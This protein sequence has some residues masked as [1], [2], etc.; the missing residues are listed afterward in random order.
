MMY[1]AVKSLCTCKDI[2]HCLITFFDVGE[3]GMFGCFNEGIFN[4]ELVRKV[5]GEEVG[6]A[7]VASTKINYQ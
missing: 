3:D 6:A 7:C 1:P 4:P 2:Y 5:E